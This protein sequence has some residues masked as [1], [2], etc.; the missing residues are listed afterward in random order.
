MA[1]GNE[2]LMGR[3]AVGLV[4]AVVGCAPPR[5]APVGPAPPPAAAR[6]PEHLGEVLISGGEKGGAARV[7][8]ERAASGAVVLEGTPPPDDALRQRLVRYLET[9]SA[10]LNDISDDGR[11]MLVTTRFGE[12]VQAHVVDGPGAARTQLTFGDE[13][14]M[15]ATFVPRDPAA[16]LYMSDRGGNEQYQIVRRDS[17]SG[18]D[19]LLTDGK[20]RHGSYVWSWDGGRIA[21]TSNARNGRDMDLYVG[22]GRSRDSAQLLLERAGHWFAIEWSRDGK[23]L[24]VGEYIS[25]AESRLYVVDVASKVVTRI[26]PERPA[27]AYRSAAFDR[28]GDR[29]YVASDWGGEFVELFE[30]DVA[31]AA[32]GAPCKL[33]APANSPASPCL[34][35]VRPLTRGVRWNVEELTLSPD[36]RTLAFILNE[37]GYGVLHLLD[38]RSRTVRRAAGMPRGIASNLRFSRT[39]G[40]LTLSLASATDTTDAYS[41]DLRSG[42]LQRWTRSEMGGLNRERFVEPELVRFRSFDGRDIPAFYYRPPGQGPHPVVISIHGGPEAQS[43]PSFSALSQYLATEAGVAVLV[44]NVRGSDGYG[45]SFLALDNGQLREHSVRDIGA[46]L[47]WVAN[48]PQLDGK[49]VAVYGGSY[50]GYM[51]L[52][53]LIHYADRIRAGVDVVGISNFV[54]FL[55][56]TKEYRRDLR[57]VEYGDERDP[58]MREF[59]NKISPVTNAT[60][61]RSALFVAHGANDPRVPVDETE[62]IVSAVRGRGQD[63]WYMVAM[64]E[65]HGFDRKENRDLFYQLTVQFLDKHLR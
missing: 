20:S 48:Q 39:S 42:R 27:A 14:V 17:G 15:N 28:S 49:R 8:N 22:D 9:R 47:D 53:S 46:L 16:F 32:A 54:T 34:E 61:I 38:T 33:A 5:S 62:Q 3:L 58:A 31:K 65:G 35:G 18:A 7:A 29:V 50:G 57:R 10:S 1:F 12:T 21:Y 45:K 60:R 36:G 6:A 52:A 55:E 37:E 51:V 13:P 24:L 25:I 43:R 56:N 11:S 63:V 41:Y 2:R 40:L 30:I 23:R 44:P 26:T 19:V 4:V 64:N 59:L